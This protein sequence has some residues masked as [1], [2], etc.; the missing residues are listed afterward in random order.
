VDYD[1]G[2]GRIETRECWVVHDVEWLKKRHPKWSSICSIIK[3]R[4]VRESKERTKE[5]RYYISSL[6]ETPEQVLKSVRSHW[7]IENTLHWV[8][9]MSFNEDYS[10]IR[11]GNAPYAM[12][13]IR[14][15]ALNLLQLAKA[16][17]S[18]HKK[19]EKNVWVGR[20]HTGFSSSEKFF[21]RWPWHLKCPQTVPKMIVLK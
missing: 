1:K 13:I 15:V 8:L 2:H 21:M 6:T 11:K 10:R 18:V 9:D 12:A 14:H 7:A 4:S 16:K 3:I 20:S 19:I 17:K 5:V